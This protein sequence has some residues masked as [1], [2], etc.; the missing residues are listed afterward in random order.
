MQD[1]LG[2][3]AYELICSRDGITARE[4]AREL[5][6]DRT[7]V[8]RCLYRYPFISDLCYHDDAY[9]WHGYIRQASPHEGLRDYS[10]WYGFVREF[11]EQDESAW[12]AELQDGCR[13]IGRNLNDTRGLL[14]SFADTR[15]VMRGLFSDLVDFGVQ[16]DAWEISFELRIRRAKWVRIYADVL[17][18]T[19]DAAFSLEFKMKD[20]IDPAEVDQAVKYVP[21]LEVV[22]GPRL[23]VVPALVL[24]RALDLFEY[25][26]SSTGND[27]AVA[28]P[29]LLFNVLDEQLGFLA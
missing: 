6:V 4:I 27:V 7:E 8:N 21:Y 13:R 2:N 22:L 28:S 10:G 12:L 19:P 15:E 18:I 9:R 11:M 23:P 14:H 20:V 29:D 16:G 1:E 25:A 3:K 17:V 24:T 5:G 26:Q